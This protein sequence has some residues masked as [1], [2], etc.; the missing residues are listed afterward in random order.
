[1]RLF[2]TLTNRKEVFQPIEEGKVNIYVCGPTVYN[3]V[4]IGNARP[5]IVFDVL[6]RVFAYKGYK[7]TFVSNYTD[8]DDKIIAAAKENKCSEKEI[9]EKYIQAYEQVR[10]NLYLLPPTYTPRVTD[11]IEDII[12]FIDQL[13]RMG[14]AY[15]I[16]GD[17]YF[18]VSKSSKYGILSGVQIS[19]LQMGAS[20]R[21]EQNTNKKNPYDFVL[22]KQTESGLRFN[23][24]W[25]DGRPGWH[26]ECVVMIC[27]LFS[28]GQVDIHGGGQDLKFPHHENEIAQSMAY[29]NHT[30]AHTWMHNQLILLNNEKMS[31]S[32]GN[33]LWAK[34]AIEKWGTNVIKWLMLSSHYRNPLAINEEVISAV[35]KEVA[36]V[37]NSMKQVSLHLQMHETPV[38]S[39]DKEAVDTMVHALEDDLNTSLALTSILQVVKK[40]NQCYRQDKEAPQLTIL[41]AT[42]LQM[43]DILGF[44]FHMPILT[45]EDKE[46]YK[47]WQETKQEKNYDLADQYRKVLQDKGII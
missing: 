2:N 43:T 24:P 38:E 6:Q 19:D 42:V 11:M 13:I 47:R 23:S 8:V 31:K 5:M 15:E 44:A 39:Y 46:I 14:Y 17:V 21:V 29:Q 3:H 20:E 33:V 9:S 26:T 22:W 27:K 34:D 30:I 36:K 4:H 10:R 7:V 45:D 32:K 41:Y 37:V 40:L 16:A 35:Q 18:D 12:T 28:H 25:S 1:M